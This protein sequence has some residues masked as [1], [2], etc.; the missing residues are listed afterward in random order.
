MINTQGT[1]LILNLRDT[2]VKRQREPA[3]NLT[4]ELMDVPS[5]A[6]PPS[7]LMIEMT[8]TVPGTG[9]SITDISVAEYPAA[10]EGGV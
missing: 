7:R 4:L 2:A 9:T 1:R 6:R 5:P 3:F 10:M 8:G